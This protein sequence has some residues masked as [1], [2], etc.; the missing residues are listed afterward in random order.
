MESP[1]Y[2]KTTNDTFTFHRLTVDAIPQLS[3]SLQITQNV[4]QQLNK[5]PA[6]AYVLV[7]QSAVH[8]SDFTAETSVPHLRR[9]MAGENGIKSSWSVKDVLGSVNADEIQEFLE[10]QCDAGVLDADA[11]S[12]TCSGH[13]VTRTN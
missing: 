9:N 7:S 5:C 10:Q 6:D 3:T 8:V 2:E 11:A 13:D 4:K 12:K 1:I